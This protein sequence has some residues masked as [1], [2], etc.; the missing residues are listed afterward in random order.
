[1]SEQIVEEIVFTALKP[2]DRITLETGRSLYSFVVLDRPEDKLHRR[3]LLTG[4]R[5]TE[6]TDAVFT[7]SLLDKEMRE[8]GV[9]VGARA[10]FFLIVP[11]D[12][13][14][15]SQVIT[16]PVRRIRLESAPGGESGG[17]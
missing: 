17:L 11:A 2:G 12:V 3:G 9:R 14:G 8:E 16:S 7:G 1:M 4:G 6:P 5:V 10:A 15:F 13:S